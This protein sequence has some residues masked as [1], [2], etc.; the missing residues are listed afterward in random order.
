MEAQ[1]EMGLQKKSD[2][3][4]FDSIAEK[5][6]EK[7]AH[8]KVAITAQAKKSGLPPESIAIGIVGDGS[9]QNPGSKN[10]ERILDHLVK[11]HT[12][13]RSLESFAYEVAASKGSRSLTL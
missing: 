8:Y 2:T 9:E 4:V 3:P 1:M 13:P 12:K 10:P 7:G 5:Y 11:Q 6:P